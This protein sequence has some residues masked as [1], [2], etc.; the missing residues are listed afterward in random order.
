MNVIMLLVG[1]C[2]K[3]PG[4]AALNLQQYNSETPNFGN[5]YYWLCTCTISTSN[6]YNINIILLK[7]KGQVANEMKTLETKHQITRGKNSIILIFLDTWKLSRQNNLQSIFCLISLTKMIQRLKQLSYSALNILKRKL[8][9][10]KIFLLQGCFCYQLQQWITVNG[11]DKMKR[12]LVMTW[13]W[14][15]VNLIRFVKI[16]SDKT[17]INRKQKSWADL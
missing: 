9:K 4:S 15:V 11:L 2:I 12:G 3:K 5:L 13:L 17:Y 10:I 6:P 1:I 14:Y 7:N 16:K 8:T